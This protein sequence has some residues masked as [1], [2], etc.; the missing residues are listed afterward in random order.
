LKPLMTVN[1]TKFTYPEQ[2]LRMKET[3]YVSPSK[4]QLERYS[5]E[6]QEQQ[7]AYRVF[8]QEAATDAWPTFR[9][10]L[11][12]R[13]SS[14]FGL[15]RFFNDEPRAPHVGL[16][17]AGPT[18]AAVVA[19]ADAVVA[20]TG[21]FFFNGRTVILDHGRGLFSMLCH[22]SEIAVKQGDVIKAGDL[23]GKVGATGRATGPHLHWTVSLNDQRIDPSYLLPSD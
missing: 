9:W 21:D 1:V 20:L 15:Q 14:P 19:P 11:V 4:Q 12:G 2:R 18:G 7:A 8:R 22:F 17:I 13:L 10:P 23:V 3:K 5:R 6:A 16:D